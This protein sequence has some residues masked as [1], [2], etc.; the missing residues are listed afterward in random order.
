MIQGYAFCIAKCVINIIFGLCLSFSGFVMS[1]A[2]YSGATNIET[3]IDKKSEK[4]N[5]SESI[6][7]LISLGVGIWGLVMYF[8]NYDLGPFQKIIFAEMIIFFVSIGLIVLILFSACFFL[9]CGCC[10]EVS[11][12]SIEKHEP[13]FTKIQTDA[14]QLKQS[15]VV[16]TEI[17]KVD[18]V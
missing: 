9:C 7:Q 8:N 5:S 1:C 12:L 13:K 2:V 14:Q 17:T 18:N 4:K 16:E 6:T 3:S 15:V 10:N 11:S